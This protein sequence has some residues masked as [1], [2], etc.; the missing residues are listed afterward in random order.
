MDDTVPLRRV[1]GASVVDFDC[2]SADSAAQSLDQWRALREQGRMLWSS[3]YDGYW[4][5][6]RH[7]DIRDAFRDWELFSSARSDPEVCSLRIPGTAGRRLLIPEELD[8]PQWLPYRRLISEALTPRRAAA[9]RPR[10]QHWVTHYLAEVVESGTIDLVDDLTVAV[11]AAVVLE[12]LGFPQEEWRRIAMAWHDVAGYAPGTP[13]FDAA[14]AELGWL[15]VRIAEM[16]SERREHPQDDFV[17][18]LVHQMVDR[19][20]IETEQVEALVRLAIAGGVETTTSAAVAALLHMHHHP[21]VRRQLQERPDLL[22]AAVEEFLRMYPPARTHARTVTR[23]DEFAGCPV[24][25]GDRILLSEVSANYDEDAFPDPEAF[26][27]DRAPNNHLTFGAGIHRC[28]GA[29]LARIEITEIITQVLATIPDYQVV[30]KDVVL[31]PN[32][33]TAGGWTKVP[34]VFTPS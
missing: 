31:Y 1:A 9:M 34:A 29:H 25:R 20:G 11:P 21:E 17:S 10:V 28:P 24:S 19:E 5:V 32:W 18:V 13:E 2:A 26:V 30:E 27:I 16:V 33:G 22:P 3:R 12:W 8:P 14:L 7:G 15:D 6:T 23:D 4:L